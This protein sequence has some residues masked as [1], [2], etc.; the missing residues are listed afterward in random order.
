MK[1]FFKGTIV[2]GTG[3]VLLGTSLGL[4]SART[5]PSASTG[6]S[7]TRVRPDKSSIKCN[8]GADLDC[9]IV[10]NTGAG[11]AI[12]GE[13]GYGAGVYAAS[14]TGQGVYGSA[15]DGEGVYGFSTNGEGVYGETTYGLAGYFFSYNSGAAALEGANGAGGDPF[16][17]EGDEGSFEVD[18]AGNG[19]FTGNVYTDQPPMTDGRAR[20][21][22]RIGTFA[23]QSTRATIDDTGTA[24]LT[25]GE[26][27]VRFDPAFAGTI[28]ASRG[29]QVFL[30][31]NGE[32]RGWLYVAA[33]YERGFIV[34]EA[35]R[36]RS[37]I[38]FDYR[39]V[40]HPLGASDVRLPLVNVK[41]PP[42]P[43]IKRPMRKVQ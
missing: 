20:D 6:Q 33:K 41:P 12:L 36:G 43:N 24:R 3:A 40:A 1:W 35:E 2:A 5:V 25:S 39:I 11:N 30:T 23:S 9:F 38:D 28:D 10:D 37:S 19:Y 16:I 17:A 29:Y 14:N 13:A 7:A 21:G 26:G 31:P 42:H 22:G 18:H 34:R 8:K 27:V 32:T 15:P 4:S